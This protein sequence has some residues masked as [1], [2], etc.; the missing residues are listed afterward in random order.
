MALFEHFIVTRFNLPLFKAK[1]DGKVVG[2]LDETWLAG[3]FDLF[4]RYCLPSVKGQTCQDFRWIVLFDAATPE[5]FKK[6]I[7]TLKAEYDRLIPC[8]VDSHSLPDLPV[9]YLD[10]VE[11]YDNKVEAAYPGRSHDLD[12]DGERQLRLIVPPLLRSVIK[13]LSVDVPEWFLTSRL[14]NDD[15]L[16]Q[17]FVRTVQKHFESAPGHKVLDFVNTYKYIE[18]EGIV[19]SYP[20]NN[21]H[22]IT[23]SEPSGDVFQSV[24]FWNHLYV[25]S[26][27]P[28]DHV[29][30]APLQLEVVHGGNVVN[31]FTEISLSGLIKG[32]VSFNK[33]RFHSGGVRLSPSRFI[34][35]FGFMLKK[36][37]NVNRKRS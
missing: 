1:V 4:E 22:F 5:H 31:D 28:V 14:D 19:Y 24:L 25:E 12:I 18:K 35:V 8:F 10:L 13:D 29:Y 16:H 15:A 33:K 6:R 20:L 34:K 36:R 17:N 26:F 32:L 30:R 3:R 2:N 23:L 11:E 21:G 37:L 9:G 27:L 7:E